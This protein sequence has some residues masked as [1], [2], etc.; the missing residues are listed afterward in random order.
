MKYFIFLTNE[1]FAEAPNGRNI[2]NSQVLGYGNWSTL[3]EAIDN[4]VKEC[5][6]ILKYGYDRF[7]AMELKN[8]EMEF[9]TLK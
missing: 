5:P 9:L 4:F 6:Y 2:E 7:F 3:D 1:G 8:E